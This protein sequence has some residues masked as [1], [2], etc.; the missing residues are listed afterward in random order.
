M[1]AACEK[2]A[3]SGSTPLTRLACPARLASLAGTRPASPA[4]APLTRPNPHCETPLSR[5]ACE[6]SLLPAHGSAQAGQ[7]RICL[8]ADSGHRSCYTHAILKRSLT[9]TNPYLL[10]RR[11]V[12]AMF[13]MTVY[14]STG[15]EGSDSLHPTCL[16]KREPLAELLLP[17]NL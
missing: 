10:T 7:G 14:A 6:K 15:I 2:C 9:K 1:G 13:Q 11:N 4:R 8:R 5:V 12:A 16:P 3:T 17:V